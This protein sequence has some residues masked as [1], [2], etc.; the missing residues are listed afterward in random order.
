MIEALDE[1]KTLINYGKYQWAIVT[2]T[3]TFVGRAGE[4]VWLINSTSRILYACSSD[5]SATSW[6]VVAGS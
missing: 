1:I 2:N 5:Q 3:P 4:H 6:V